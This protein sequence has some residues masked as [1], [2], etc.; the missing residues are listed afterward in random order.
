VHMSRTNLAKISVI[1][2]KR[3]DDLLMIRE[4]LVGMSSQAFS[5]SAFH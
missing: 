2:S 1:V 3:G 4:S 5:L